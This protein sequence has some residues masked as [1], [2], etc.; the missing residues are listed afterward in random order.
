MS[1]YMLIISRVTDEY[2]LPVEM[3]RTLNHASLKC[4][5]WNYPRCFLVL[6]IKNTWLNSNKTLPLSLYAS[7]SS[8]QCYGWYLSSG[9]TFGLRTVPSPL[10]SQH[11]LFDNADGQNPTACRRLIQNECSL[12]QG[13]RRRG[14]KWGE[15]WAA[16]SLCSCVRWLESENQRANDRIR[17]HRLISESRS[18]HRHVRA[19]TVELRNPH[20]FWRRHTGNEWPRPD[21]QRVS[22]HIP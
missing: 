8:N 10:A 17:N 3:P 20:S 4:L 1:A 2:V 21:P 11:L 9:F 18:Q 7:V 13:M 19:G 16:A 6:L 22:T 5:R 12:S 15:A 14:R